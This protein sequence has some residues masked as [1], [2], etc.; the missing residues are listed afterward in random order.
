MQGNWPSQTASLPPRPPMQ[1]AGY[2]PP[3]HRH[4]K[5]CIGGGRQR[6]NVLSAITLQ[7]QADLPAPGRHPATMTGHRQPEFAI[8]KVLVRLKVTRLTW[9]CNRASFV[10]PRNCPLLFVEKRPF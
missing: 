9:E 6:R 1:G 4:P 8:G 3:P 7:R 2:G 5:T 10:G